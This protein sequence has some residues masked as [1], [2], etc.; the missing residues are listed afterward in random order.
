MLFWAF[1]DNFIGESKVGRVSGSM[2]LLPY[3]Q[4]LEGGWTQAVP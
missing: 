1:V 2:E 4:Q 3:P